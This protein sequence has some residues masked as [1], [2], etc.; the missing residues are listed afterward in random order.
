MTIARLR[1]AHL[2]TPLEHLERL[3][4]E[5]ECELWIKR[6]D[7]TGGPEAGN[8]IRKHEYLLAEAQARGDDKLIT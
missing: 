5:L 3:S 4:E 8:K 1:L 6:D 7:A 2:P